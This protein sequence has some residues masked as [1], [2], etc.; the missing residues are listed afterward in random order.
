M[1]SSKQ[2]RRRFVIGL[3]LIAAVV[4]V[5][6]RPAQC[7]SLIKYL[8]TEYN[9]STI[10]SIIERNQ[11]AN[12]TIHLRSVTVFAPHNE[13]FLKIIKQ[14]NDDEY[15]PCYHITNVPMKLEQLG[16]SVFSELDGNPPMWITKKSPEEIYVNQAKVVY[17]LANYEHNNTNGKPQVLHVI[18]QVL[19]PLRM[20]KNSPQNVYNPNAWEF[21]ENAEYLDL[22]SY[23]TNTFLQRVQNLDKKSVFSNQGGHTFFIPVDEVANYPKVRPEKIDVKV[24]DAH[25]VPDNVLFLGPTNEDEQFKTLA[26]TDMLKVFASLSKAEE[27]DK[28]K[29]YVSSDTVVGDGVHPTGAVVAEIVKANIPVRNGVVHLISRPLMI[30]DNTVK[31]FIEQSYK[32]RE[33]SVLHRFYEEIMNSGGDFLEKLT[34]M[35]NVT[36]F[37]PSNA[38]F[39]DQSIQ[40]YLTNR[41]YIRSLLD[42]HIVNRRLSIDDIVAESID[43]RFQVPTEVPRKDLFFNVVTSG[44][45]RTLTLEGGGVNATVVQAN[46][47]A[48]NGIIH[49]IDHVLGIPSSTVDRKL[50]T[51]PTLNETN[52]LG[53]VSSLNDQLGD[54][55]KR[56]TYFVPRDFAWKR[57]AID[58]PSVYKKLFMPEYSNIARQILERHLIIADKVFTM[59]DLK[60]DANNNYNL[61][62]RLPTVRDVSMY[63][64]VKDSVEGYSIEWRNEWIHVH[65]SDVRCTNGIIHVIDKVL[66]D[67]NDIEVNGAIATKSITA[68]VLVMAQCLVFYYFN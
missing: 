14:D 52:Y 45:N 44:K 55:Q 10:Y 22:D 18:D 42:L 5:L 9:L 37:A 17:H 8:S 13:A 64:K 28:T 60:K 12:S 59:D 31:Q 36:L 1:S 39:N 40:L 54:V 47:A 51:D 23:H 66:I 67:E 29:Y 4:Q 57:L 62:V 35:P 6:Y 32:D 24:I 11:I 50:A 41:T 49:I 16:K 15:L 58:N 65:R 27:G 2:P 68:L 38:A 53:Q 61:S 33:D 30:V 63:I 19:Q 20:K 34:A 21:M 25:I 3:F 46:L 7:S 43:K 26:F 48:T 56:F